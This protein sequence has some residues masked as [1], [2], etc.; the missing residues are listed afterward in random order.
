[1]KL[2]QSALGSRRGMILA[3]LVVAYA[4]WEAWLSLS[5]PS[6][7]AAPFPGRGEKVNVLVTLPF[8]AERFHI[9]AFQKLGRVS[10]TNDNTVEVRGVKRADLEALAR[11][12]W[13]QRVEP[14]NEGG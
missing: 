11:P 7:L 10:G 8:P 1:M 12:Y 9:Q 4:A 3:T 5:A 14:L 2:L 6:K 13:V